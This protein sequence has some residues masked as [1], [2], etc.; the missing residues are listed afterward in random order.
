[1]MIMTGMVMNI[2]GSL[3]GT[4]ERAELYMY[5]QSS[6]CKIDSSFRCLESVSESGVQARLQ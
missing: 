1:M 5:V 4:T 2:T 6:M 3:K